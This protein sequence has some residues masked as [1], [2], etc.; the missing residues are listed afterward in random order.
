MSLARRKFLWGSLCG[1]A[2]AAKKRPPE[3]PPNVLLIQADD[4]GAWMTGCYGNREIRTPNIDLLANLGVRF[5]FAFTCAPA[6]SASRATLFT[7]RVPQQTGVLDFLTPKPIENPPQGQ[8][9]PPAS[10]ASEIMLPDILTG[11]GYTCGYIGKWRLG[12]GAQPQHHFG[13]WYTAPGGEGPYQNPSMSWNGQMVQEKGYLPDLLTAKACQFLDRQSAGTPFFLTV[14]YPNP[15]T[16]YEGHPQ[17]Y[18]DLY[19]KTSFDSIGWQPAAPNALRDKEML[20]DIVGNLRKCA[21][22]V[23]ALDD[24]I[25]ALLARLNQRGLSGNTLILFCGNT[26]Q[27]L[28][29]HGLWGRAAG[30]Y[31][32]NLYEEVV[33]VPLIWVW[34]G[35][36]PPQTVR[37][38]L[39]ASYDLLPSLCE[40]VGATP[41]EDRNLTG[42]SYLP[43]ALG[44][45]LPKKQ[46]WRNLVFGH[47]RNTEMARDEGYKLI[48][49]DEG[50]GPNALYALATDPLESV[51]C[52]DDPR[53]V[54]ARDE[55]A[56]EL[57]A[58]RKRFA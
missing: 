17:K 13:F 14:S 45:P 52:Y 30:S 55:L 31:P 6:S 15:H 19:A 44:Q 35:R 4:L 9:A 36:I 32:F 43:L 53:F 24:Q 21:A 8:A 57:A 1:A 2:L 3:R 49:R 12:N 54:E 58:W 39:V 46:P 38:E 51:N 26:G 27:L 42:R 23:T 11:R 41:P 25:P 37:T 16:P 28:G 56:R 10:F 5:E 18:Y 50:R 22:A 40:A 29:R 34:S 7:G 20:K 33:R 48:L 47:Y